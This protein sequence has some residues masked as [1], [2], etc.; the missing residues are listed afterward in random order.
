MNIIKAIIKYIKDKRI[1]VL[2]VIAVGILII[3]LIYSLISSNI[4]KQEPSLIEQPLTFYKSFVITTPSETI[5]DLKVDKKGLEIFKVKDENKNIKVEQII[6]SLG[7]GVTSKTSYSDYLYRWVSKNDD[8]FLYDS[9]LQYVSGEFDDPQDLFPNQVA[10]S[11]EQLVDLLLQFSKKYA[12]PNTKYFDTQVLKDGSDYKVSGRKDIFG[13]PLSYPGMEKYF[14]YIVVDKDSKV[15]EFRI[16]TISYEDSN[17]KKI[18]L[19][20]PQNLAKT[21]S[22]SIYPKT[23]DYIFLDDIGSKDSSKADQYIGLGSVPRTVVAKKVEIVYLFSNTKQQF[24]SPVYR[25]EGEGKVIFEK[26]EY[27]ARMVV[28]TNALDPSKVYIPDTIVYVD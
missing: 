28:H 13:Y 3:L 1:P 11:N 6:S 25:I 22:S 12:D 4:K 5:K 17:L 21:A 20:L 2:W 18:K 27:N 7:I 14:D 26:K 19:V 24:L 9:V 16:S 23:I 10:V 15:K 8:T